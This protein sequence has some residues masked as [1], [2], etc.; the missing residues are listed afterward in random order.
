MAHGKKKGIVTADMMG[1]TFA[2]L[3]D[4]GPISADHDIWKHVEGEYFSETIYHFKNADD[5]LEAI[6]DREW[7]E[8]IH[9]RARY[10]WCKLREQGKEVT[11]CFKDFEREYRKLNPRPKQ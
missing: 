4:D 6:K 3:C 10:E 11:A 7:K 1:N 9:D 5:A 2:V 8:K